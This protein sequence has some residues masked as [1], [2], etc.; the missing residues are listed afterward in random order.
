M[1]E[2]IR[3][4]AADH[5]ARRKVETKEREKTLMSLIYVFLGAI[6]VVVVGGLILGTIALVTYRKAPEAV[7]EVPPK[8][9]TIPP[10]P[11]EHKM[12]VAKHEASKPKPTFPQ[13]LLSTKP[14]AFAL[15]DLPMVNLDQMLP[16]DPSELISDQVTNMMGS[17]GIGN[18]MGDGL[19]GG[20][21]T[22]DG[23]NFMGIRSEGKRILLVFDVS[24]SVVN[25][26][27]K[28]GVPFSKVREETAN[29]VQ[30]LPVNVRFG[31]IQ[32]VRNYKPFREELLV[33]TSANKEAALE[34]I[35][36]EWSDSGAM[37]ASGRGVI[38]PSPNGIEAVMTAAFAM[39][40]D[41]IFLI[42]DASFQ[43]SPDN[44]TVDHRELGKQIDGHQE[45]AKALG[46]VILHF[47]GFGVSSE[48]QSTMK[49][50]VRKHR[51][52]FQEIE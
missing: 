11:P 47:I 34:W 37:A 14:S 48:D 8:T 39:D 25:K 46:G 15:P 20:G 27:D 21:G 52:E 43:R 30:G 24:G 33:A 9:V 28:I 40:P 49:R 38:S 22:G 42:S 5:R 41:V 45:Q 44:S 6:G 23:M 3:I 36:K 2:E 32:F 35:D 10:K 51:G 1:S 19:L 16:L 17:S 4:Q 50:I 31:M 18:G 13:K 29:L 7:F 12:N 26:A